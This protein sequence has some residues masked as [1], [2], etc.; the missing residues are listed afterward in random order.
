MSKLTET[1]FAKNADIAIDQ[2]VKY[3][4]PASVTL[5]QMSLESGQG[6]SSLAREGNNYFGIKVGS[7]WQ[8]DYVIRHDDTPTDKFRVYSSVMDS[9]EDHSRLLLNRYAKFLPQ[10]RSIDPNHWLVALKK[11]GY[12]SDPYYGSKLAADINYYNL[13][14]YDQMA[15]S[16]AKEQG[17]EIGYMLKGGATRTNNVLSSEQSDKKDVNLRLLTR[18]EGQRWCLPID[19]TNLSV[20]SGGYFG[21]NRGNHSHGGIDISTKGQK[22]P[23]FATEDNGTIVRV[24]PNNGNAG[25]MIVVE[26]DRDGTKWRN[27]YMHLDKFNVQVGQKV[28]AGDQ[29]G[30]SGNTGKSTGPHLHFETSYEYAGKWHKTDPV[31]YLKELE[32]RME[33]DIPLKMNGKDLIV[34][35]PIKYQYS[36]GLTRAYQDQDYRRGLSN[37]PSKWLNKSMFSEDPD[38]GKDMFTGLLGKMFS[39]AFTILGNIKFLE[40]QEKMIAL[41]AKKAPKEENKEEKEENILRRNREA[42]DAKAMKQDVSINYEN[43][44][45]RS[46]QQQQQQEQHNTAR[47]S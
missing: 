27:T 35:T 29:I 22:L 24:A 8:G 14:K 19:F 30:V 47:L 16:R 46:Q 18:L 9:V 31:L 36:E 20:P 26:Y 32:F 42:V 33:K 11:G 4:I 28:N 12:A 6:T 45:P 5:A 38:A 15:I 7:G 2:F 40:V 3:G 17:V 10:G 43:N 1:F 37:D 25:N 23:V 41:E 44:V 34:S 13:T 21:K 39:H